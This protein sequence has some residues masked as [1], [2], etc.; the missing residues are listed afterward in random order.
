MEFEDNSLQS[1]I[2]PSLKDTEITSEVKSS[3]IDYAMSVIVSRALPDVRDGLKPVNRRIIYGMNEAGYTPDKPFVKCQRISGD[4]MGKYH[5]HGDSSIYSAM[6]RLAQDFSMRYTLIDGHGN[7]GTMDGDEAAAPRYTEARLEKLALEMVKDIKY[8]TVDFIPN[9]DGTEIEP[10]ILP[11]RFPNLLV[12]GSDG[13]AV[14]MATKMPPHNLNEVIDAITAY[15]K[16]PEITVEQLMALIKGPDFP[17]GGIIYGLSGIKEAYETGKGNFRLRAKADIIEEKNGKSKIIITEIPY[18]VIKSSIVEKIGELYRDKKLEGI[19]SVKDL[20]KSNVHIEIECKKGAVP[21]VILNQLY[22][23]TQLEISYGIINLA[24]VNGVPL[25]LSLKELLSN[26]VEF[27]VELIRRRTNFLLD[28]DQ[29]RVHIIQGLLICRDN[30]DEIVNMVKE[31]ENNQDFINKAVNSRF[32]F[33]EAQAQAIFTLQLGRLTHL[34]A[35]KLTDE[36]EGLEKNIENYNHILSSRENILEV[37]LNELAEIKRKFGDERKSE[38]STS[39]MSIEDEDLI[40][41]EDVVFTLTKKGYIKRMPIS[42]FRLQNRGGKG[43]KGLTSYED[44]EVDKIIYS[45]THVDVLLFSN[46]GK[47]YRVRGYNIPEGSRTSKGTNLVNI[48]NL[49]KEEKIVSIVSAH[50]YDN[51]YLVLI[52]KKGLIKRTKLE[53]FIRINSNGKFAIKFY[54]DDALLDTK[55]TNGNDKILIA[56]TNGRLVKFDENKIRP[57]GRTARGVHAIRLGKDEV[58]SLSISSEGKYVLV[59]SEKGLGKLSPTEDYR[60]TNRNSKGVITIKLTEKTGNLSVMKV[61]NGDEDYVTLTADG[62][63][64]RSPLS[65]VRICGRNSQGVKMVRMKKENDHLISLTVVPHE[66]ENQNEE[67]KE[68]ELN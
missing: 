31:S 57:M 52:T 37:M 10:T 32:K 5:P 48:V 12:N 65:Q 19:T 62:L 16:N 6:V 26:Y 8:N 54:D 58:V 7:F 59:I 38:I 63:L 2:D 40:P 22:K 13:I 25:V 53:E 15:T 20:S 50:E 9:Y 41:E 67:I 27:Q 14:G 39:I 60:E 47:I 18:Q 28:R 35:N 3:F 64:S 17:T 45:K 55:V 11:S 33:S 43:V 36:K 66:E 42:E 24:I 34:E 4:I 29:K 21:S 49:E 51:K 23:N 30:I 68:G 61:V 1:G 46:K 56:A 44:D